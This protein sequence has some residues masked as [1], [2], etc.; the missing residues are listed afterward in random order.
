MLGRE[1]RGVYAVKKWLWLCV[2]FVF[3]EEIISAAV[4]M[5]LVIVLLVWICKEVDKEK[6]RK[7]QCSDMN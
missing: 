1:E 3:N 5:V 6:E 2:L 4:L 7:R